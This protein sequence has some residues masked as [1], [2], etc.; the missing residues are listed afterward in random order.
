MIDI[1]LIRSNPAGVE[2]GAR[3]KRIALDLSR[4]LELDNQARAMQQDIDRMRAEQN[5]AA[6]LIGKA[7]PEERG[8]LAEEAKRAKG[9][10]KE[11]EEAY[12]ACETE[13][14]AALL[15]VPNIPAEAVPEG[16]DDSE[17][18]EVNRAR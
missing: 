18:V 1:K 14:K 6:K 5:A 17:N 8:R 3:K 15:R 13:L 2:A 11:L 4:I 12:G 10:L 7:A 9:A 16:R